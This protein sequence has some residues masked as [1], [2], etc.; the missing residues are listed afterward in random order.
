M[1]PTPPSK[2]HGKRSYITGYEEK[3]IHEQL[4][5]HSYVCT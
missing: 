3:A 1:P 5:G 4:T 2:S